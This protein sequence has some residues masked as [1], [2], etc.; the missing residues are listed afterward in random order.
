MGRGRDVWRS[1][2]GLAERNWRGVGFWGSI[3]LIVA[4]WGLRARPCAA[5]QPASAAAGQP[6][7]P[8]VVENDGP[9]FQISRLEPKFYVTS[10]GKKTP[11]GEKK[12]EPVNR[13]ELL[14]PPNEVLRVEDLDNATV[15]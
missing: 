12:P 10:G 13:I 14:G 5:A 15:E 6:L 2:H 4:V 3:A 11:G 1:G 9:E 7:V 8:Q